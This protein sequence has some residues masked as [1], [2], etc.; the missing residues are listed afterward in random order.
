VGK[1]VRVELSAVSNEPGA[2]RFVA[3]L[4]GYGSGAPI[5]SANVRLLFTPLDDP[6]V[7]ST[8]LALLRAGN[9]TYS[10]SGA[11]LTFDGRWGVRVLISRGAL[12][13]EVPLE[14]DP[15]GPPQQISIERVPG[16]PPKY[17]R[18]DSNG[19]FIRISP[20]PEL[21]GPSRLFVTCYTIDLGSEEPIGSL[22][23][24]LRAGDG[25]T[26]QQNVQRL[27]SGSF[28]SN[29]RLAAGRDEIAVIA[30]T[31]FGARLR[32]V[33]DLQVPGS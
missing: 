12:A 9:G 29:I 6:G 27:G 20:H 11:N 13:V 8:S 25:P 2:N 14:L 17:T 7:A 18:L 4:S 31:R 30:H 24:T 15:I 21:D 22:V 32:S 5:A 23:V 33:F 26:L 16:Q 3:R 28:L 1:T 19:G 10:G